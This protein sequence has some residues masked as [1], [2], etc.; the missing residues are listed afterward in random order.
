MSYWPGPLGQYACQGDSPEPPW[1]DTAIPRVSSWDAHTSIYTSN[2]LLRCDLARAVSSFLSWCFCVVVFLS[3][4]PPPLV[5]HQSQPAAER[6]QSLTHM[7]THTERCGQRLGSC[8]LSVCGPPFTGV[9]FLSLLVPAL[10][11]FGSVVSSSMEPAKQWREMWERK[12]NW[13][14]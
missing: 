12:R 1:S 9:P 11:T 14:G 6:L 3:P 10:Q 2:K 5:P 7:A 8:F 4:S 13:E